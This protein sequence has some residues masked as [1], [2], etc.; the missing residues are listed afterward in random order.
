[1]L[2]QDKKMRNSWQYKIKMFFY[3]LTLQDIKN[4]SNSITHLLFE[5]I[6]AILGLMVLLF[7]PAFFH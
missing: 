7:L 3:K 1:M 4:T 6:T 2:K 5:I